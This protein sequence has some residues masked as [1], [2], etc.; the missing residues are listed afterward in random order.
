VEEKLYSL[1]AERV[2]IRKVL[3]PA[4]STDWLSADA[5][6]KLRSY[7]L[8]P[9]RAGGEAGEVI[10]ADC[11]FCGSSNTELRNSFG[12]TACRAISF[13]LDCRQPFEQLKPI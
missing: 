5:R 8:A 7:G 12:C 11:P 4:W 9:P 10:A 13:C 3:D 1:G 6:E 2:Q